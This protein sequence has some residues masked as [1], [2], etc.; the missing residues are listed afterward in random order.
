MCF[1]YN[2]YNNFYLFHRRVV[3]LG[4]VALDPDLNLNLKINFSRLR[5]GSNL[6]EKLH[7]LIF[8]P[9]KL[10]LNLT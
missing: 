3:D 6:Q 4:G 9:I 8:G 5:S 7:V 10:Y 2:Y 1:I